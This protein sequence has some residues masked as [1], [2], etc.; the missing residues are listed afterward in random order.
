MV[1]KLLNNGSA[2]KNFFERY[3]ENIA[4]NMEVRKS[5]KGQDLATILS[6]NSN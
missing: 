1:C 2:T 3:G 5:L 6:Q 4:S